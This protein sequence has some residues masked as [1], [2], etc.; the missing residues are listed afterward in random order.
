VQG[1]Y[2]FELR[3]TDNNGAFSRDTMQVIVNPAS[4]N[5]PPTAN[6]GTDQ[7]ITLPT[8]SVILS[9]SGTDPD[10][11]IVTYLWTKVSGPAAGTITNPNTAATSVTGLVQGFYQFELRVTDNNGA[12][13]RDTMQVTVNIAPNIPPAANAGPDQTITLPTNNTSI[14]GSGSDP[15]GS[16]VRYDW[17]QISGPSNNVLFSLNTAITYVNNLIVGTYEFEL[18]VT[19]NRGA[20]AR[21]TVSIVLRD[22]IIPIPQIGFNDAKIYP[23]PVVD[24]ATLE[25]KTAN[26]NIRPSIIIT[27]ANGK[28][29]FRRELTSGQQNLSEKIDMRN[30]VK[31]GYFVTVYYNN[32]EK[33]T[34]KVI[35]L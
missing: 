31:G 13:G 21:D 5:I 34:L 9:G 27:D 7:T 19:D 30:L 32:G 15:D 16:I 2:Q 33:K 8:N 25:I 28:N 35:K 22:V 3:V 1:V 23:N 14:T 4:S 18:T 10:G 12:F 6:A 29:V 11:I 17:R 26:L 24:I 20:T